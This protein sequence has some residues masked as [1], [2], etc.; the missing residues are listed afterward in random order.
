MNGFS[1]STLFRKADSAALKLSSFSPP[2]YVFVIVYILFLALSAIISHSHEPWLDEA[3]AW[4]IARDASFKDMMFL[5]PHYEGHPPLWTLILS[6]PA[7]LGAP[8]ELS[9]HMIMFFISG[10]TAYLIM[11]K[12]PFCPIARLML[13][14]TYYFFY[15]Y[16]IVARPYGLMNLAIVLAAVCYSYRNSRPFRYVLCLMLLCSTSAYG[17]II[18][19][20]L[21]VAWCIEILNEYGIKRI[22]TDFLRTRRFAALFSLLV[23]AV[24]TIINIIPYKDTFSND[25]L[26]LTP[27][28]FLK[29]MWYMLLMLPADSMAI[30]SR[31]GMGNMVKYFDFDPLPYFILTVVGIPLLLAVVDTAFRKKKLMTFAVPYTLLAI[32]GAAVYFC[33][34]HEG[35][36]ASL[37]VFTYWICSAE[38]SEERTSFLDRLKPGINRVLTF[39][40]CAVCVFMTILWSASASASDIKSQYYYGREIAEYIKEHGLEDL[41]IMSPWHYEDDKYGF[42]TSSTFKQH[43]AV[44]ISPYFDENIFFNFNNGE[45]DKAYIT[46][47]ISAEDDEK[48]YEVWKN[49]VPDILIGEPRIDAVYDRNS[50]SKTDYIIIKSFEYHQTWQLNHASTYICI[51]MRKDLFAEHPDIMPENPDDMEFIN[52][53]Y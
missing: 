16:G 52:M 34:H 44:T 42:N 3:Q 37:F 41:N 22:F 29:G 17:I 6:I 27:L 20:G 26:P 39:F 53:A 36:A 9:L 5:I 35:I 1:E 31:Y 2:G 38:K 8:Y 48:N 47:R 45:K 10:L 23:Y 14:F 32:F 19:G 24:L 30:G 7:K 21:A 11:F 18:S 25:T 49:T 40:S 43:Q 33:C 51:Y 4:M 15:Q 50:V 12:A 46:H 28:L 13:P